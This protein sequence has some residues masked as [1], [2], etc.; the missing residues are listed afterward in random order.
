MDQIPPVWV[1]NLP[2]C[3]ERRAYISD[4]LRELG[5]PFAIVVAV[6]GWALMMPMVLR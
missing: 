5:L 4:H 2:R 3:T 1:I 6:E